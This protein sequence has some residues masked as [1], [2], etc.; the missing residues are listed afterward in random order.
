[1][2]AEGGAFGDIW[3]IYIE[4]PAKS[5]VEPI[6]AALE[7]IAIGL[8]SFEII[9]TPGWRALRPTQRGNPIGRVQPRG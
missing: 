9:G 1:M 5:S 7:D 4:L 6:E 8:S 2:T 3:Q